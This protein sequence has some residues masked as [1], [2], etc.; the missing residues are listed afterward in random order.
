MLKV[1]KGDKALIAG[2]I[3]KWER[4]V[5]HH[6]TEGQDYTDGTGGRDCPLC[7]AYNKHFA[8]SYFL[9]RNCRKC[10]IYLDTGKEECMGVPYETYHNLYEDDGSHEELLVEAENML[11]Y[12]RQL[13]DKCEESSNED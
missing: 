8:L 6:K 5:I 7:C 11:Q 10:P 9:E 3:E 13:Q 4:V 1:N 2:S 12:L